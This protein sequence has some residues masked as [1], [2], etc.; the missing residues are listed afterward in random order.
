MHCIWYPLSWAKGKL[1]RLLHRIDLLSGESSQTRYYVSESWHLEKIWRI[2]SECFLIWPRKCFQNWCSTL[3]KKD[4]SQAQVEI[5][6]ASEIL[7]FTR[8]NVINIWFLKKQNCHTTCVA[9]VTP[10]IT[11]LPRSLKE[12][13]PKDSFKPETI[14]FYLKPLTFFN[15]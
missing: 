9:L 1:L 6:F 7:H 14:V 5:R 3:I 12:G 4:W 8:V 10:Y 13:K 15:H 11:R 2:N